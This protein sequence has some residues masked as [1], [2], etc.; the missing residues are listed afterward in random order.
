MLNDPDDSVSDIDNEKDELNKNK[1][2]FGGNDRRYIKFKRSSFKP[3][4]PSM[5]E[6]CCNTVEAM[7]LR[8]LL[9]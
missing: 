5:L 8:S 7:R 1:I 4:I 6:L 3:L 2:N 9:V